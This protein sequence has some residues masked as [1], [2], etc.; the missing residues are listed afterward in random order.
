MDTIIESLVDD[1][2]HTDTCHLRWLERR[3]RRMNEPDY[4]SEW[5]ADQC[6][7][8]KYFI[9]LAGALKEDWGV[10]SN[11]DAPF[12]GIVRFEHDGCELCAHTDAPWM[13]NPDEPQQLWDLHKMLQQNKLAE[14]WEGGGS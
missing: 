1:T 12:D 8:C 6:Y 10:C 13:E 2:K 9:P 11:P 14:R 7:F 4:R 5:Y 3:N